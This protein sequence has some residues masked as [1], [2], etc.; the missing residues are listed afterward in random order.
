[1]LYLQGIFRTDLISMI[2]GYMNFQIEINANM[3][4]YIYGAPSVAGMGWAT[5]GLWFMRA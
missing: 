1:M 5:L 4:E 3:Y 2:N